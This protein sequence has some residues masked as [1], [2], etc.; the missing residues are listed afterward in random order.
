MLCPQCSSETKVVDKRG[1]MR[2]RECKS[3]ACGF[4]FVTAETVT[5]R[6][7]PRSNAVAAQMTKEGRA[8]GLRRVPAAQRVQPKADS[9]QMV[10]VQVQVKSAPPPQTA[11]PASFFSRESLV[12][13][14]AT[15]DASPAPGSLS[16]LPKLPPAAMGR[17][18]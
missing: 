15:V 2:R 1:D 18:R 13:E 6:A 10:R 9:K 7:M 17:M 3:T 5:N 16:W 14:P 8:P 4:R 12:P 11:R